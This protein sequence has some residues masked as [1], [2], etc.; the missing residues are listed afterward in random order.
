ME[1]QLELDQERVKLLD[2]LKQL[3]PDLMDAEWS[4]RD[5]A[6]KQGAL[7]TKVKRLIALAIALRAGCTNCI[8]AQTKH[9]LNAGA[10]K[11]ELLETISV[12]VVMS[13]TTGVAESLRVIKLL[14][15]LGKL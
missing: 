14:D 1:S 3:L 7:S 10:T 9:A 5:F 2:R 13:G 4:V 11:D 8:L 15:E 6:Y 12:E